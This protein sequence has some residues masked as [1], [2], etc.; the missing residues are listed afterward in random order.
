M[1]K[2][3]L[4]SIIGLPILVFFVYMGGIYLKLVLLLLIVGGMQEVYRA[5]SKEPKIIH[6]IGYIFAAVY[7]AVIDY[8]PNS[9]AMYMVLICFTLSILV[10]SVTAHKKINVIDCAVTLFGFFYIAIL[11]STIYL[12]RE[13]NL[14]KHFVWLIF[15]TAWGCDTGAY[16]V[17]IT[18]GKHKLVPE[19]SPKKTIEGSIGGVVCAGIIA[20]V[21]ALLDTYF[22]FKTQDFNLIFGCAITGVA[23]AVFSQ[24]GDL[25]ASAIKRHTGIKDFGRILPGHGGIIDRFDSIL[26]TAPA[27]YLMM[28]VLKVI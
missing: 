19:L 16:F 15:I 2:R 7:I 26:F 5:I 20:T 28:L 13:S 1:L 27:V 24:L 8:L 18:M 3:V 6:Y 25:T 4:T 21:Y 9:E 11:L 22:F 17:G 14:G 23:G 10:L 12:V